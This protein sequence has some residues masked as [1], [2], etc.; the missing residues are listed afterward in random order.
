MLWNIM[1]GAGSILILAAV[2]LVAVFILV[3]PVQLAAKAM[4]ARRH[5]SGW[6][7]LALVGASFMQMVGLSV[8]VYGTIAAFLLSSAAFGVFLDTGLLRGMG[9][10]VLHVV[11]SALLLF[12]S[13]L[14]FGFTFFGLTAL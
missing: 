12:L 3:L 10:S 14:V 11:F 4:G 1:Y 9:I 13:T 7:L 5:G 8:P 2:L 6:C